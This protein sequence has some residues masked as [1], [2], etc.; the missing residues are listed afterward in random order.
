MASFRS[1]PGPNAICLVTIILGLCAPA[2][3]VEFAGGTGEPNNP[4]QIATAEQLW[5]TVRGEYWEKHFILVADI[6]CSGPGAGFVPGREFNNTLDGSLHV[7]RNLT[8]PATQEPVLI[9]TIGGFGVVRNLSIDNCHASSA[10]RGLLCGRNRGRIA[11]CRITNSTI[12]AIA[13]DTTNEYDGTGVLAAVNQGIIEDCQADNVLVLCRQRAF[14]AGGLV[15]RNL[16]VIRRCG[17]AGAISTYTTAGGL[18]GANLGD[19]Q[20]SWARM[21]IGER[22]SFGGLVGA[23]Y[24]KI[25]DCYA[26]GTIWGGEPSGGLVGSHQSG[27]IRRCYCS[28]IIIPRYIDWPAST[29]LIGR[30]DIASVYDSY[31]SSLGGA[32][33]SVSTFGTVVSYSQM[34]RQESFKGW[35]F[36]GQNLEHPWLMP[37]NGLPRLAWEFQEDIPVVANMSLTDAQRVLEEYGWQL[38]EVRSDYSRIVAPGRVIWVFPSGKAMPDT[39]IDM[40]VS[41]G[42]FDWALAAAD[43]D[44]GTEEHPLRIETAGQLE[45]LTDWSNSHTQHYELVGDLDMAGRVLSQ[46]VLGPHGRAFAGSLN[47]NRFEIHNLTMIASCAGGRSV[48]IVASLGPTGRITRLGLTRPEIVC[49]DYC[50]LIT[51]ALVGGN[52]GTIQGCY[53]RDAFVENPSSSVGTL[54][55][56]NEGVIQ[57]CW[58]H[59]LIIGEQGGGLLGL[60]RG[61]VDRCFSD[62]Q[63]SANGYAGGLAGSNEGQL[64]NCYSLGTVVARSTGCG[65]LV[66]SNSGGIDRCYTTGSVVSESALGG[67]G[68]VMVGEGAN[69]QVTRSYYQVPSENRV[70]YTAAGTWLLDSQMRQR[71]SFTD[72]DFWGTQ[73]DG[74]EDIWL[75]EDSSYPMLAWQLIPGG[76]PS[77]PAVTDLPSEEALSRL[78]SAG[79]LTAVQY[80]YSS[81]V[82]TSH[83]I[84]TRV[85]SFTEQAVIMEVVVS[86]GV[87]DWTGNPGDGSESRP[88]TISLG[89]QMLSLGEH[90][91]LWDKHFVLTADI[92]LAWL[93]LD[94]ALIAADVNAPEPGFQ[95]PRFNGVFDGAGHR[96][97]N[98]MISGAQDFLGLF[99]ALGPAS[100]ISHLYMD[101]VQIVGAAGTE[102]VGPI[103][104]IG[105]GTLEDCHTSGWVRGDAYLD[106]FV[107]EMKGT[108]TGCTSTVKVECTSC[109]VRKR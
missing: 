92:D 7:V 82:P 57:Q 42:R 58:A 54:A 53:C 12:E 77:V 47:G 14:L 19:I 84:Q 32:V 40:V 43:P 29:R 83:V 26:A 75:M 64:T 72:W 101:N 63:V 20:A 9:A 66:G 78:H 59:G 104:G 86:L 5:Q 30:A 70:P 23:N 91:E 25:R 69:D 4:Y 11:N 61:V 79:F 31:Y 21:T 109:P 107:G 38:G 60:N 71:I 88:F 74:S 103:A 51:G 108:A 62:V 2:R 48:G 56:Y 1:H 65:S 41:L 55:A 10:V 80:E 85:G 90:P 17:V 45:A 52:G 13:S 99:G 102:H 39:P 27:E 89:S 68:F 44:A 100:R 76:L 81:E 24:G 95:G 97:V 106:E 87:Y 105:E 96:L 22:A 33:D 34:T 37:E 6:D 16:G 98:L 93:V 3:P 67:P 36:G 8:V 28:G 49:R 73:T 94:N 15:G 18:V 50:S 35:E 46:P